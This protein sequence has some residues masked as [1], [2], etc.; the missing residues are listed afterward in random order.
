MI[1]M[2]KTENIPEEVVEYFDERGQSNIDEQ[3][4]FSCEKY[5]RVM[6]PKEYKGL[7]GKNYKL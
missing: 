5:G 1:K 2:W 3:P 6:R 4:C 7:Y